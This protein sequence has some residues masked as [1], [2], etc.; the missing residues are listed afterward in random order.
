MSVMKNKVHFS[1]PNNLLSFRP[2]W[3]CLH[4]F[5]SN[6]I[7]LK[8]INERLYATTERGVYRSNLAGTR[9]YKVKP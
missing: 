4:R 2:K 7:G 1:E 8:V 6:V 5:R 3:K 9:W